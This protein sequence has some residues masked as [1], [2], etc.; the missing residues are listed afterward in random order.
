[1]ILTSQS[2]RITEQLESIKIVFGEWMTALVEEQIIGILVF[3]IEIEKLN[4]SIN[5]FMYS[6]LTPVSLASRLFNLESLI[7]KPEKMARLM[8]FLTSEAMILLL[9]DY[10]QQINNEPMR[11]FILIGRIIDQCPS[12]IFSALILHARQVIFNS[13]EL[14]LMIRHFWKYC[15]TN[16]ELQIIRAM[17]IESQREGLSM[18]STLVDTDLNV[19]IG[20]MKTHY[21]E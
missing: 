20:I 15:L 13:N 16:R 6:F 9:Q 19:Y 2:A 21:H 12:D 8:R 11:Y 5:E 14:N 10:I 7:E 3:L 18:E 17:E 4:P 1:M